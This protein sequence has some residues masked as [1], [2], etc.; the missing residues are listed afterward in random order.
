MTSG[1]FKDKKVCF[2]SSEGIESIKKQQYSLQDIRILT[3]LG[4][5]VE[6]ASSFNQIPWDSDFYF[7]WWGTGSFFPLIKAKLSNRP[8]I[9]IIGGNE[10]MLYRDSITGK[11]QGY[12]AYSFLK[13]LITR[14]TMRFADCIIVVSKFMLDNVKE[15]SGR[16]PLVIPNSVDSFLFKPSIENLRKY[17]TSVFN[18][19]EMPYE[20]K[21]GDIFLKAIS[22]VVK[23]YPTLIFVII[24]RH[25][26]HY[27]KAIEFA[28]KLCIQDNVKFV[29][30]VDNNEMVTWFQQSI[31]YVQISDTETF[32]L[33]VAEAM[34]CSTPVVVSNRGALPE[35]VGD[36]GIY[37]DNNN[38][39]EVAAGIISVLK[40]P[41]NERIDLGNNLRKRIMDSYDYTKRKVAITNVLSTLKIFSNV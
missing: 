8:I 4:F 15:L 35:L 11:A 33:S 27:S 40:K 41:L 17:V 38:F 13:Q 1:N 32:G 36:L 5:K 26:N 3:E 21:R 28:K 6:I 23:L 30:A 25:G 19:D 16:S 10:A 14:L 12:L 22:E 7:S 34:S 29:G 39:L 31:L 20:L 37:V 9:V 18:L 24:G 2:F